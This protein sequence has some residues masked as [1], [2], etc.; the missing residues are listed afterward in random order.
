[1]VVRIL[2]FFLFFQNFASASS[3]NILPIQKTQGGGS[4]HV[5]PKNHDRQVLILVKIIWNHSQ[6]NLFSTWL[7]WGRGRYNFLFFSI[8][9]LARRKSNSR[10]TSKC[11]SVYFFDRR[12]LMEKL[13]VNPSISDM[14]LVKLVFRSERSQEL[15]LSLLR[16]GHFL[17]R[18]SLFSLRLF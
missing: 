1:M 16:H 11:G 17:N 6:E 5:F 12:D 18:E 3:P 10:L 9:S 7:L 2:H 8:Q 14:K 13:V 4:F 15:A